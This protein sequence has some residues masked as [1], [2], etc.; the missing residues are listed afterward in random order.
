MA[1]PCSLK[2]DRKHFDQW[3]NFHQIRQLFLPSKFYAIRYTYK[4]FRFC[5]IPER[6]VF[7]GGM[8]IMAMG[9]VVWLPY[10]GHPTIGE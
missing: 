6:L 4:P 5:R 3:T 7:M 2:I 10:A 1:A 8:V 9:F